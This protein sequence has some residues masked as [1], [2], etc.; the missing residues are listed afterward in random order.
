MCYPPAVHSP[1]PCCLKALLAQLGSALE[2]HVQ[3]PNHRKAEGWGTQQL[4]GPRIGD[5]DAQ[6]QHSVS[7]SDTELL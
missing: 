5:A 6:L 7:C 3:N 2:A 4:L 1:W